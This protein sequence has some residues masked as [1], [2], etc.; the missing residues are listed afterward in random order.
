VGR[1]VKELKSGKEDFKVD[2]AGILHVPIGR[3]SFGREKIL[4]NVKSLLETVIR[5]KP[6]SSKGVYL[7]GMALSST[8]GPGIR[9]DAAYVR[10]MVR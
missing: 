7:R 3:V 1:A 8:M 4:D 6:A 10:N 9:V 5:L 2:K